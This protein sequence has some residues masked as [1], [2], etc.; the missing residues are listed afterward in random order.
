MLILRRAL[1]AARK[2]GSSDVT[3]PCEHLERLINQNKMMD[4]KLAECMDH[5][6]DQDRKKLFGDLF[7]EGPSP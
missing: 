2:A 7:E 6:S 4:E 1:I 3:V 5:L